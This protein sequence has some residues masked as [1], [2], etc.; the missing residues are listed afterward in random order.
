MPQA[1]DPQVGLGATLLTMRGVGKAF[2]GVVVLRDID[3]ALRAGEVHALMGENGA[4]KSTLMRILSGII[5]EF[6]GSL[7]LDGAGTQFASVREAQRAGIAIIHQELNLVPEMTVAENIFLGRE[8]RLAGLLIDRAA[9]L[10]DARALLARL[11]VVLDPAAR[12][13]GLRVGE[14]Q[15]VEIAKALSLEAR[16]LIMDEPT[17]ALSQPECARLF[18]VIRQLAAAGVAVVYISH[19]MDEVALLADRVTVL[20]DGRLAASGPA[21][22]FTPAALIGH[23][24]GRTLDLT[25]PQRP[26]P[27][28]RVALAVRGLGLRVANPQGGWHAAISD[29]SF[30]VRSGEVFGIGG[31]LGAGRTEILETLFGS[32]RGERCGHIEIDGHPVAI[33]GPRDAIR[34][35][36]ALITEDRK[37]TGLLLASSIRDNLTL[38]SL[39]RIGRFGIRQMPREATLSR[40]G[41]GRLGVRCRGD[42][43][44]VGEL[45]GG[46]Q[47]KVVLGKWLA[48]NPRILLLDEPTRGIDVGAK[49]E[50]YDVVFRLAD[51]GMAIIVV[52]SELPELL[53]LSDRLLVMCEG[54]PSGMLTRAQAD[55]EA[56]MRLA[57]PRGH[58][59][60]AAAS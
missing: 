5:T 8:P 44:S 40:E 27:R 2:G 30:E 54:R 56:V 11:G 10:R 20:R 41:I 24:V 36:M 21:A 22:A 19:R 34:H 35:G 1:T 28:G 13:G 26:P 9:L 39:P 7:Y 55:Q 42:G 51:A 14:R 32:A 12:V 29:V 43:Q 48:T 47:Q 37:A 50:I 58:G 4:G 49:Q 57:S 6:T 3:L 18:Q 23:M 46:N 16:I 17:S 38:P 33:G 15:L 45:S 31:L 53:L 52:T 25:P 59:A 60:M